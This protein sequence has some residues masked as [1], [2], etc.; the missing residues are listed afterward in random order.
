MRWNIGFS[1][2]SRAY[3]FTFL[4][5]FNLAAFRLENPHKLASCIKPART[6][7]LTSAVVFT[8]AS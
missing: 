7:A 2:S 5:I 1:H 8:A 6:A 3:V 4:V